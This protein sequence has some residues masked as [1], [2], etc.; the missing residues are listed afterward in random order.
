MHAATPARPRPRATLRCLRG[1]AGTVKYGFPLAAATA[2]LAWGLVTFPSG[3]TGGNLAT[4]QGALRWATDYMLACR[5]GDANGSFVAQVAAR[6]HRAR[7]WGT[8]PQKAR[9]AAP[10][11]A[12]LR[13]RPR[14]S[15]G[16]RPG[17]LR[18]G[19]Q[20]ASRECTAVAPGMRLDASDPASH[21][22]ASPLAAWTARLRCRRP[23]EGLP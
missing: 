18:A 6:P 22:R 8:R 11:H 10:T 5:L 23:G 19:C 15:F 16:C 9:H 4:A 7:P 14:Q 13:R 1:R 20:T 21:R 17:M 12:R 3:Y 2:L